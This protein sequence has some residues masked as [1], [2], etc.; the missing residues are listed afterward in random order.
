MRT[1]PRLHDV[2]QAT[3]WDGFSHYWLWYVLA[4]FVAFIVPELYALASGHPENTLSAQ[5]WRL[6]G[7]LNRN[8]PLV[9]W[10]AVHFLL[11]G[12][13]IVAFIWLIGHFTFGIWR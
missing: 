9:Q 4:A 3:G 6:E 10:T 2:A 12:V 5:V 13:F 7:I 11:G 1:R 8:F